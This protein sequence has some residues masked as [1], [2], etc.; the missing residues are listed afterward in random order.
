M[1]TRV[2]KNGSTLV[3]VITLTL[4]FGQASGEAAWWDGKKKEQKK[5]ESSSPSRSKAVQRPAATEAE[6]ET[7]PPLP[8]MPVFPDKDTINTVKALQNIPRVPSVSAMNRTIPPTLP[9]N[10]HSVSDALNPTEI[11]QMRNDLEMLSQRYEDMRLTHHEQLVA[12]RALSS[13]AKIHSQILADMARSPN[14]A[15]LNQP[16]IQIDAVNLEKY[17]LIRERLSAQQASLNNIVE[18]QRKLA[19]AL[20]SIKIMS[21]S[22]TVASL[23]AVEMAN[24]AKRLNQTRAAIEDAMEEMRK[25]KEEKAAAE[26]AKKSAEEKN[27]KAK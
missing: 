9:P 27:T 19:D 22:S 17:R 23:D 12:L 16:G 24:E 14:A 3:L 2:S 7:A 1:I 6:E 8:E 11:A 26:S 13:Q 20:N 18:S 21:T 25:A 4:L 15:G 5:T 10:A